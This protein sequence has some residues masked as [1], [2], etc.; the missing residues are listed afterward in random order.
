M[1]VNNFSW[2]QNAPEVEGMRLKLGAEKSQGKLDKSLLQ[3]DE[4]LE[5][6]YKILGQ[7]NT[8]TDRLAGAEPE[9][10]NSTCKDSCASGV[11]YEIE[12]RCMRLQDI[13][14]GFERAS[15]RLTEI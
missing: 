6:A 15:Q 10:P 9:Q 2:R 8:A 4:C 7:L 14:N 3:F 13:L 12:A 11:A 5:R 1:K